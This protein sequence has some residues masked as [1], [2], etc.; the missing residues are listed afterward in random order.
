[1]V[2]VPVII[3][4]NSKACLRLGTAL[5]RSNYINCH[6]L[7]KKTT[8]SVMAKKFYSIFPGNETACH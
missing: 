6:K 3:I 8:L 2:A 4:Y 5:Q 7:K 1:M